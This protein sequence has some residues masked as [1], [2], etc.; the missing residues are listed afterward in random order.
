VKWY[1]FSAI[2]VH[3]SRTVK[4]VASL[5][6]ELLIKILSEFMD[7]QA[8]PTRFEAYLLAI[9]IIRQKAAQL[10]KAGIG[11]DQSFEFSDFQPFAGNP[12]S[13]T[14]A[15]SKGGISLWLLS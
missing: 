5:D 13:E 1:Q 2:E 14:P 4:F 6:E 12:L 15:F 3:D 10:L 11:E 9:S 8:T 7:H